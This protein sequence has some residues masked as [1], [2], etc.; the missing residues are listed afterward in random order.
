MCLS[1]ILFAN[2]TYAGL[3]AQQGDSINT[4]KKETLHSPKKAAAMSAIL[5]GLGQVYNKKY[6]KAPI[7]Y[8]GLIGLGYAVKYNND[9]F[10]TYRKAYVY[11]VDNKPET[12]DQYEGRY[13][14]DNLNT[15]QSYFQR[16]RDLSIVGC[17]AF[18]VIN[19]IDATVDAHLFTFDV[20]DDLTLKIQPTTLAFTNTG[21]VPAITLRI[22]YR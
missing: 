12:I 5:P 15:L 10:Q 13:S 22:S 11:R 20:S 19:I 9:N 4:K 17:A 18:Y 3:Y 2:K 21:A 8:A 6:W 1:A 7:I 14:D 16:N